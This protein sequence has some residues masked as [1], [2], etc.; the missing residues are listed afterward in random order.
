MNVPIHDILT[1]MMRYNAGDP[2]RIQ[3]ALKVYTYA[4]LIGEKEGLGERTLGILKTAAALH[5][6]GI[7]NSEKI[8]SS[9]AGNWQELEGPPVAR[10]LLAPFGLD[11]DF[12]ERVC[13]LIGHHHTYS[14]IDGLDYQIL[15]EADLLV[16]FYEDEISPENAKQTGDRLFRTETGKEYLSLMFP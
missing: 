15:V 3:H 10:V 2:K 5:D 6:I 9:S 1:E 8:H 16:N 13:Y 14:R 4:A 7:H 11:G 12:V